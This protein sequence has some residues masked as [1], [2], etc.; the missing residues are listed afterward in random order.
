M[1]TVKVPDIEAELKKLWE[2]DKEAH[3]I[4]ACLFNLILYTE[5]KELR[6]RFQNFV[7]SVIER[8]PCR[9]IEIY[10]NGEKGADFLY[11]EVSNAV[12]SEGGVAIACDKIGIDFSGK[13]QMKKVPYLV[14]PHLVSDLPVYLLWGDDPTRENPILDALLKYSSRLI[15]LS[16]CITDIRQFSEKM[17]KEADRKS[18]EVMDFNWAMISG[19]RDVIGQVFKTSEK[20]KQIARCRTLTITYNAAGSGEAEQPLIQS[21]YLQAW[22][23]AQLGWKAEKYASS[24]DIATIG[25]KKGPKATICPGSN[26]NLPAGAVLGVVVEAEDKTLYSLVRQETHHKVIV[27]VST[28]E[29]CYLPFS[30]YLPSL[31]GGFSFVKELFYESASDHYFNMLQTLSKTDI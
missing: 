24:G 7:K 23:A 12:S 17:V 5:K 11:V 27:H 26:K 28:E 9:I 30:L 13:E 21:L 8:F 18:Y 6:E 25:Y 4:K 14:S 31:L 2:E 29:V 3:R 22:L 1:A 15:F 20:L 10:R 16:D 19:W